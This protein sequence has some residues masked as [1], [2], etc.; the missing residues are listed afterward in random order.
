MRTLRYGVAAA[1]SVSTM[2][3]MSGAA[4]ADG[5][6]P[7]V[8]QAANPGT[9][10][11]VTKTVSTPPI[12]PKPDIVLLVD[13][14]GS[15]G[16]ELANVKANFSSIVSSVKA[17]QPDAQ[18]AVAAYCDFGDA[19]PAF[20]LFS[21][22]TADA[23]ALDTAIN[24]VNLCD[25]GDTPEAQLNALWEIGNGGDAVSFRPDS[26]RIVV[27][28]G[29]NPGHDPSGG[30]SEGD[31]TTSLTDVEAKVLAISTG[32]ANNLDATGQATRITNATGGDFMSGVAA[33]DVSD[34]IL[35]GLQNLDVTVAGSATCDTGLSVSL[36]PTSQTV[37]SGT[38]AIFDETI[39]VAADAQQ[40]ATLECSVPFTL[41][42]AAAG[43]EFTQS[44]KIK[45]NDVTAPSL[46]CPPGPNPA[47]SEPSATNED[48][49]YRM[50]VSD[51]V[52]ASVPIYIKDLGSG[53][54]FGPYASGT[55]FKLTQA[56]GAPVKA[57]DFT[58][59]V[60]WKFTFNGDAQL[61][62]TD[63]AGNTATATCLVPPN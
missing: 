45:V 61:I 25:G 43:P 37:Q 8:D 41:N 21:N 2:L 15:M 11:Q 22:L 35:E 27:W 39:T 20:Q 3:A 60:K 55:T 47:G 23:T 42:G 38:D 32:A 12:P 57:R 33:G 10:I 24:N 6:S 17:V 9:V 49:F 5:V 52:D 31:A 7:H 28:Y 50:V 26:S 46:S 18:F 36:S 19:D 48:G 34:A 40:G 63:A 1:F 4:L 44:V 54:V 53:A 59:E 62:A 13:K 58:G 14:T 30:H 56:P 51:N 16:V 29:D